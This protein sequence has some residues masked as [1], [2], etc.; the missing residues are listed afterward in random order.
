MT[1]ESRE[2]SLDQGVPLKCFKF[3][4]GTAEWYYTSADRAVTLDG[5]QYT[6]AAISHSEIQ[7]GGDSAKQPITITLPLSLPVIDNWR[8][9]PPGE[10]IVCTVYT[11]HQGEVDWLVDW[12]GRVTNPSWTDSVLTLRSEPSITRA[13]RGGK[14]RTIG[15]GCDHTLYSQ[16]PGMC[17][18]D[19][20]AFALPAILSA[21]DGL[22]LTASEFLTLPAGRLAGGY[23]E[24]VASDGFTVRRSIASHPGNTVVLDYGHGELLA[25]LAVTVYPG[26]NHT[27]EDCLFFS[28]TDNYGGYLYMSDRDY[29]DGN[30]I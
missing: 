3:T 14:G 6:P 4:R 7:D 10:T 25:A 22:T 19:P 8:P 30:P 15:R 1:S 12:I 24:F 9:Y 18:V 23:L 21:V 2:S 11:L 5:H 16:G 26:C 20:M 17:N 29:Y 13:K 28:N 27:W